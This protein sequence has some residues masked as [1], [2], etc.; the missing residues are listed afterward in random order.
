MKKL[1]LLAV[2][3]SVTSIAGAQVK[4][5]AKAGLNLANIHV[6]PKDDDYSFKI[7]PS[8]NVAAMA[9]IPLSSKLSLQPEI[10]FSIQGAKMTQQN[11]SADKLTNQLAYL[12]VPVLLKYNDPSGFFAE[13][14]PQIGFL[15]SA[16][17]KSQGI[18]ADAKSLYNSTDFAGT[19]GVGYIF[20]FNVGIDARYNLGLSNIAKT[21]ADNS[22]SKAKNNV[23][24]FS[25]FYQFGG[26]SK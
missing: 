1:I 11:S 20:P 15:L 4:F 16:K 8:V 14:G 12:N 5:G 9:G 21:D 25:I 17:M 7:N 24:Q 10:M 2:M 18:S 3:A 26:K 13:V 22:D 23:G 19:F 6:S